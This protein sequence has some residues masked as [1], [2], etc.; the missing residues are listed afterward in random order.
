[1]LHELFI[2]YRHHSFNKGVRKLHNKT[3]LEYF[4]LA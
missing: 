1:M 3:Q 4:L 2:I